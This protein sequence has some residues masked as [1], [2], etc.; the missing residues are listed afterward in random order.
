MQCNSYLRSWRELDVFRDVVH[1]STMNTLGPISRKYQYW[2]YK[3][4]KEIRGFWEKNT[5]CTRPIKAIHVQ[6]YYSRK[7]HNTMCKTARNRFRDVQDSWLSLSNP[8]TCR[9]KGHEEVLLCTR[10]S[11]WAMSWE[12]LFMPYANNKGAD[13]PAHPHSLI[14][15]FVVRCLDNIISQVSISEIS[16]L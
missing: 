12:N 6:D 11:Y 8:A 5:D 1:S 15:T 9:Q 10:D 16:S 2:F 4:D 7:Q 13:Q 3:N 14:S